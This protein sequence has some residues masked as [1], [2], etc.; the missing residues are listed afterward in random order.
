MDFNFYQNM[1]RDESIFLSRGWENLIFSERALLALLMEFSK[2]SRVIL[3]VARMKSK[4]VR[5]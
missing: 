2:L 1:I 3:S 5:F 4:M